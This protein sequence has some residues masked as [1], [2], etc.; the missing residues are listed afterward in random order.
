MNTDG[1]KILGFKHELEIV[2]IAT[3]RVVERE[4]KYNRI[5]QAGIDFL[6]QSPFGDTPPIATWYCTLFRNNVVPDANTSAADLPSVLGEFV[7]YSEATRP[8]FVRAYN[9]AGTMDN[10]ASK[11]VF[12]PTADQVVY[13]S[14]IV[15]NPTKGANTGL[16]LSAVRFSTIKSLS[17][18]LEARLVCGLTYIPTNVI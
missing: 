16:V 15:S 11:A 5:P 17:I 3:G 10:A 7:D 14:V 9:G 13:G 2:E 4:V 18:G 6:I 1:L 12:T 8:E